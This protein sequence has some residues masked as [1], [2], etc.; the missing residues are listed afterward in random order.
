MTAIMTE[1][2][3]APLSHSGAFDGHTEVSERTFASW[4]GTELFY[5]AWLPAKSTSRALILLHRGHEHSGRL[6]EVVERLGVSDAAVFAWD[7]RGHG[8]SPGPRGGAES[9]AALAKDLDALARHLCRTH[10]VRLDETVVIAHS[11]GGVVAA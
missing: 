9:V 6:A 1:P 11:V 10:G 2:R 8:R 5:R 4:D 7:Q 3:V